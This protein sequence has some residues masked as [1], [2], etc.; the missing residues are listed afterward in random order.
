M[1]EYWVNV[2]LIS[3]YTVTCFCF[4]VAGFMPSGFSPLSTPVRQTAPTRSEPFYGSNIPMITE[5]GK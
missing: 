1:P 3:I 4:D 5:L 2:V